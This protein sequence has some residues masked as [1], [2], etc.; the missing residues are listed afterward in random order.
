[1]RAF[2]TASPRTPMNRASSDASR[3][4]SVPRSTESNFLKR[5]ALALGVHRDVEDVTERT[6]MPGGRA[7]GGQGHE[8]PGELEC[9]VERADGLLRAAIGGLSRE[10]TDHAVGG[11][12]S[13]ALRELM[14]H[15]EGALSALLRIEEGRDLTDRELS[16]RR[17]FRML[18]EAKR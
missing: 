11:V 17:A 8:T 7:Q 6:Q 12:A 15:L 3:Q 10:R 5:Y 14:P 9:R 4:R 13:E 2:H 1:L 16:Y 18:S